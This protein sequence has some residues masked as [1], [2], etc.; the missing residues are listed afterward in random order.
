[1]E[2]KELMIKTAEEMRTKGE[3]PQDFITND[4]PYDLLSK[5]LATIYM[6]MNIVLPSEVRSDVRQT[7][8]LMAVLFTVDSELRETDDPDIYRMYLKEHDREVFALDELKEIE[9]YLVSK[10]SLF[11]KIYYEEKQNDTLE[12]F[13]GFIQDKMDKWNKNGIPAQDWVFKLSRIKPLPEIESETGFD[14]PTIR[15]I[16]KDY[17][18][19]MNRKKLSNLKRFEKKVLNLISKLPAEKHYLKEP[20]RFLLDE[21]ANGGLYIQKLENLFPS[22]Q[23]THFN[24]YKLSNP[25]KN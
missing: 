9:N 5:L 14:E 16:L 7:L 8:L 23:T 3:L 18:F 10:L 11:L 24:I 15:L 20:I 17:E 21:I 19:R 12:N 13:Y 22:E 25:Q 4:L 1:M 6:D 2:A